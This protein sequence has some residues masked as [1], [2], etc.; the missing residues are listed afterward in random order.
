MSCKFKILSLTL[1]TL[2]I[3]FGGHE[4]QSINWSS[5]IMVSGMGS[6]GEG[7]GI[8]FY[9]LDTN[10]RQEM[11]LMAYDAPSGANNF[12]Y[13]IG[14]NVGTNGRAVSW[15][16]YIV[17]GGV[18]HVGE[19]AGVAFTNL[20]SNSRPEMILMA[21]DAPGGANNFRYRIGWNVK[22]NGHA[23]SWSSYIIVGGVGNLGEGAGLTFTNLDSNSRPEMV[24]MAYDAPGGAN[25]FR[26]RIGW[27]MKTNGY[28]T[29]WSSYVMVGGVGDLGEGAG[30]ALANI[31][32]NP[33][34][35]MILM[36]Y[37]APGGANNFRYRVGWN[38]RMNGYATSWSNYT[39]IGGVGDLGEGADLA[40]VNLDSNSKPEMIL[41]A[42][43]APSGAN[44][45]R[46]RIGWNF[47]SFEI[48][49]EDNDHQF[50][51]YVSNE[52]SRFVDYVWGF[53]DEFKNTWTN[54]QYYWG[55][56]RFLGTGHLSF[57][58]SADLA[59]IAGHGSPSYIVMSSGQ[60]CSLSN[61]AWGSYSTSG[62]T[63]DLEY[64]VFH[65]CQVLKMDSGWRGRWRR[66]YSTRN[67]PRPFSGLHIAM[68]FRTNHYNGA[69]AGSWAADEFAENLED[70]FNVRYA[71][72]EAAEDARWLAGWTGNKPAI[73][74]IRPHKYETI[75]GHNSQDYRYGDSQYLLDAYY[76]K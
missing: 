35:E 63:G 74:Y 22:T 19:G 12:R 70:G 11:I 40:L 44:N 51:G 23:T 69:G 16:S 9:N 4:L 2:F 36:A 30:V 64:I 46:Y 42:Y 57:A 55:Q 47:D 73:F 24:I 61:K 53:V 27:N 26:Y 56:C 45:F 41:M 49:R 72:Y 58:D 3:V 6:V 60:G 71:W 21:Y 38:V 50:V 15:S 20:D 52:E 7:A 39:M 62:R 65:S 5:Y 13:R 10:P 34:P 31:D 66:Y 1:V 32:S 37:D 48:S 67:Q 14:W 18:G 43:D 8:A 25:N 28:A 33:R 76:M 75:G 59:Y 54:S 68:G 29:S 17:V